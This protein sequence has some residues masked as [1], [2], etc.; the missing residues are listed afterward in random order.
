[1]AVSDQELTSVSR[2]HR[3][4]DQGDSV[5]RW[6]F[7]PPKVG[8]PELPSEAMP[9]EVVRQDVSILHSNKCPVK[10][11]VRHHGGHSPADDLRRYTLS[12]IEIPKAELIVPVEADEAI[13]AELHGLEG[14]SSRRIK[15]LLN[16][17]LA[18]NIDFARA[19]LAL[20]RSDGKQRLYGVICKA[21]VY[22]V[23]ETIFIILSPC[24]ISPAAVVYSLDR[25]VVCALVVWRGIGCVIAAGIDTHL[26]WELRP[27][28]A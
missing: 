25:I 12:R 7:V 22:R 26:I 23:L 28:R 3:Q 4:G 2:M 8:E 21:T 14:G 16:A 24:L 17:L 20:G 18:E 15:R 9:I 1:M 10:H 27:Y 19:E 6:I 13:C 11:W 5:L